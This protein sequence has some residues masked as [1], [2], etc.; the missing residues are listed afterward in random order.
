MNT[1]PTKHIVKAEKANLL[2]SVP[3][4]EN[5]RLSYKATL[6]C[7][8][9]FLL[10]RCLIFPSL[11]ITVS[12][13]EFPGCLPVHSRNPPCSSPVKDCTLSFKAAEIHTSS[14]GQRTEQPHWHCCQY[15]PWPYGGACGKRSRAPLFLIR[16]NNSVFLKPCLFNPVLK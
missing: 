14:P 3:R 12:N 13:P 1:N 15:T 6:T 8:H 16:L 5:T 10:H 4:M 11:H 2:H 7:Q 9:T